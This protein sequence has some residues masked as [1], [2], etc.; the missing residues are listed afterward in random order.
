MLREVMQLVK[1]HTATKWP[2]KNV[3]L[4]LFGCNVFI[5]PGLKKPAMKY[6]LF[7]NWK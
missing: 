2:R 1:S 3:D 7:Q 4:Y 6:K 5:V